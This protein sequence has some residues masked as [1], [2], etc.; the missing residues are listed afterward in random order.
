[1]KRKFTF[2]LS[3]LAVVTITLISGCKKSD[4]SGS[5]G[6]NPTP[7]TVPVL[8]T[9]AATNVTTTSAQSGGVITSDGGATI[10]A[11]GVCWS[12]VTP[13]IN[14]SKTID[15]TGTG[16]FTSSITNLFPNT[17]YSIRAYATN[18]AGT[19]Y[20]NTISVFTVPPPSVPTVTTSTASGINSNSAVTGGD[21]TSSG[22]STVTTKGICWST[23]PNPTTANNIISGG[24][25]TG[26]FVSVISNLP[27]NVTYYVRAYATNS[28]GT[29]Y[30]NEITFT[31]A[32]L[33]GELFGGGRVFFVD[34][35]KIHGLIVALADQTAGAKWDSNTSTWISP[36]AFSFTDG[37]SNTNKIIAVL[38]TNNAA[39]ICRAYTAGGFTDWYLPAR[40]E[41]NI[42]YSQ[43]SVMNN[44]NP[45]YYW[46][47]TEST[48]YIGFASA[49]NFAGG[50]ISDNSLK[51]SIY[52]V[53]AIRAF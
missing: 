46:S 30:G 9:T 7:V 11:R 25:G 38:G 48:S 36:N 49:Q 28:N 4:G 31:T 17:S 44:Y 43:R 20:G 14:D 34:N 24:T 16:T 35:T 50:A 13:T 51:N 22:G 45:Y 53:R 37:V 32:Y 18:S 41:L 23:S 39:G 2:A 5:S 42:L 27:V 52:H 6:P 40:N 33:I 47:S 15:G 19:G 1:M 8:T 29:G 12:V 3:I 26:G 10:T 21:V